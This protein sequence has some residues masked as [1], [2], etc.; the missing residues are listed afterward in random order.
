MHDAVTVHMAAPPERIWD[1]VSDVTKIGKYSPETFEAEW[2]DGATGPAVGAKFRGHVK[3]NG[4]GPIYWTTCTVLGVRAGARVRVRRRHER[5]AAQRVALQARARG[6]RHRRHR[7]VRARPDPLR[8]VCTGRSS[9]G[10]AAGPIATACGRPSSA[11][12][13]TL[14]DIDIVLFDLGGVLI[15]FGGV[16]PMRELA[17][18]QSDDELWQRWLTCR[19][20]RTFERGGCTAADFAT[21]MV[22]DWD[23][24]LEPRAFLDEFRS[25]PGRTLP[26]ADA[27]VAEVRA[28]TPAGCLSNTNSLHWE[29]H[30]GTW[31]ILD[32]F[33][34]R[35]LSFELGVLKPDREV[36]DR[37]ADLLPAARGRVLFLDD[38]VINVDGAT[39]AGFVARHVRGVDEARAALVGAGVLESTS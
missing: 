26:G 1:L 23:L 19:W 37:V 6:R 21:G 13:P 27:L 9:V 22:G 3:R 31:P 7:V 15:D 20:V 18:I 12:R 14:S 39:D 28:T 34:Y 2:I 17:G 32:A 11:S 5:E 16:G 4:K 30:F 10:R 38:N 25:W 35:F 33:D 24:P 29:D 36:F 8:C